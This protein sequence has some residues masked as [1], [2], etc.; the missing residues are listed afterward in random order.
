MVAVSV[1]NID[2]GYLNPKWDDHTTQSNFTA[3]MPNQLNNSKK[4]LKFKTGLI[5]A[6]TKLGRDIL[7]ALKNIKSAGIETIY[8]YQCN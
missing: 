2:T 4:F 3:R 1:N 6:K 7:N 5:T 8:L